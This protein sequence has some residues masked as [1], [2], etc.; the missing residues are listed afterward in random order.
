MTSTNLLNINLSRHPF[1]PSQQQIRY[2]PNTARGK[3][4]NES[5]DT[6]LSSSKKKK[7]TY[8]II[9]IS[10]LT[11]ISL[12]RFCNAKKEAHLLCCHRYIHVFRIYARAR[13]RHLESGA[14]SRNFY[15]DPIEFRIE[16]TYSSS[17]L[18]VSLSV[19]RFPSCASHF[20]SFPRIRKRL[21]N[22]LQ[23]RTRMREK[24]N[25]ADV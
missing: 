11:S 9:I 13:A 20:I 16:E 19:S 22:S 17:F 1:K 2:T 23:L 14:R 25:V 7:K 10:K 15:A 18:S 24:I 3:K 6:K 5:L 4:N 8:F 21:R 12:E